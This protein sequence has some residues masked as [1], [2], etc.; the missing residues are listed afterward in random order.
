MAAGE[1]TDHGKPDDLGLA[2][3]CAADVLLEPADQVE[4]VGHGIP[5]YTGRS[6]DRCGRR[7]NKL[8]MVWPARPIL[9]TTC[10]PPAV[11]SSSHSDMAV[12]VKRAIFATCPCH[13]RAIP[14][15]SLTRPGRRGSFAPLA[16][17]AAP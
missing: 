16:G 4:G 3:E 9:Q 1:E 14:P 15:L 17:L 8:S 13:S 10:Q 12:V 6:G 11:S 2:D 7:G 5:L